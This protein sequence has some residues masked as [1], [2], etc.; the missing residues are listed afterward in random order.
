MAPSGTYP[1]W[2]PVFA[3]DDDGGR[4]YVFHYNAQGGTGAR[5]ERDGVSTLVFPPNVA[6]TSTELLEMEAPLLCEQKALVADSGG[7]GRHRGGLGQEIVIRNLARQPAVTSI[8]GGRFQEGA[9]GLH[10]GRP[11]AAAEVRVND[12]ASLDRNTVLRLGH[13][14]FVRIR[15]PGGGGFGDSL[16]RDPALVLAD[17]RRGMVTRERAGED[18]GVVLTASGA[19]VDAAA[20]ERLR[21]ERRGKGN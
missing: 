8:I 6:S 2:V 16:Q 7:P 5:R 4:P 19:E 1:L 15:L 21:A 12:G 17:V 10:G 18:Y 20:T 9:P 14:E 11:G 3:G 13:E